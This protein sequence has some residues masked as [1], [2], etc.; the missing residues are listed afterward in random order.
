MNETKSSAP[1]R[2]ALAE[3][4]NA[5]SGLFEQVLGLAPDLGIGRDFPRHELRVE[6]DGYLVRVELPGVSRE[7]IEVSLSGRTLSISGERVR[8]QPPKGARILRSERP[9]GKF[10]VSIRLPA[11]VDPLGVV[12][13]MRDGVLEVQLPKPGSRGR[14]IQVEEADEVKR[15]TR[16]EEDVK[17]DRPWEESPR[18]KGPGDKEGGR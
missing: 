9:A 16:P 1:G 18:S 7:E 4:K 11:D 10:S 6:D 3:L 13:Q 17:V 12:A 8:T 15:E 5:V 14:S 2:G